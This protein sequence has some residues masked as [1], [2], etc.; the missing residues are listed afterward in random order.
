MRRI[1]YLWKLKVGINSHYMPPYY[2]IVHNYLVC[3]K[4]TEITYGKWNHLNVTVDL[5][6]LTRYITIPSSNHHSDISNMVYHSSLVQT[7]IWHTL[8][9]IVLFIRPMVSLT[10]IIWYIIVPSFKTLFFV[11]SS[12]FVS[13][14]K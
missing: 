4:Y 13:F 12:H 3:L 7:S 5:A 8:Y 10:F 9:D 11:L 6:C 14:K 2:K 1:Q